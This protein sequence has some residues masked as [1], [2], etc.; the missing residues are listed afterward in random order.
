MTALV[1]IA[2]LAQA[3]PKPPDATA[4]QKARIGEYGPDNAITIVYEDAGSLWLKK[5]DEPARPAA[6]A[7]FSPCCLELGSLKIARRPDPAAPGQTF[8]IQPLKPLEALRAEAASA[9]PPE[10]PGDLRKPDLVELAKLDKTI[11]LDIRYATTNNFMGAAFYTHPRAFLQRPAAM[12]ALRAHRKLKPYGFGLLIHDGYRPWAVTKMFW[13]ATP[14]AQRGFVANPA[15][16][17]KHNR[18]CAV[19]LSMYDLATGQ[20]VEMPSGYDEFSDRAFAAYPGGT[21]LQRWR[22][23]LLRWAM[24]S[25]GYEV[26]PSEWWHFDYKEWKLYPVM[27]V[28]FEKLSRK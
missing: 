8:K 15:S 3:G 14:P 17:S 5:K 28:P 22:R 6:D 21:S 18:G 11:R 24:E 23:D 12:A 4:E 7:R 10:Q 19:D 13:E 9:Q 20:P 27:N 2:L 16:G 25:E 1:L 26:N